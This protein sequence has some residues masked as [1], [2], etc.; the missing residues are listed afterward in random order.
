MPGSMLLSQR[1]LKHQE[2]RCCLHCPKES[3]IAPLVSPGTPRD[4]LQTW[5]RAKITCSGFSFA[6]W[7]L[8][9]LQSTLQRLRSVS[10]PLYSQQLVHPCS[11]TSQ[12]SKGSRTLSGWQRL[13]RFSR[14][15]SLW[16]GTPPSQEASEG[17]SLMVKARATHSSCRL[18]LSSWA[19]MAA[20]EAGSRKC[21]FPR[22]A[23]CLCAWWP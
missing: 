20:A 10:S 1:L 23:L 8:F 21:V 9:A 14:F 17:Q 3:G 2:V 22:F 15:S 6:A 11:G 12:K 5:W 16:E 18:V 13:K 4:E 7:N 19:W